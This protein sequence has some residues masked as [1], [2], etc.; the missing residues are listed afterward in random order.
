MTRSPRVVVVGAGAWG[1][2]LGLLVAKLEPAALLCRSAETAERIA[3]SRRNEARLPGVDLPATLT[4]TADAAVLESAE[5]VIL[6]TPSSYLRET[7]GGLAAR[8]PPSADLVSVVKGIEQGTLLRMSEVIAAGGGVAPDRIA[9]LSGPN[10]A[11]EIARGRSRCRPGDP[12]PDTGRS[13][14]LPPVRQRGHRRGRA[15]RGPQEHHRHR[16]GGGR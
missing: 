5:L 7:M 13:A 3:E 1:T 12:G 15:R 16:R 9:A 10:L 6:A 2:T 8:I 4:A 11:P 14:P